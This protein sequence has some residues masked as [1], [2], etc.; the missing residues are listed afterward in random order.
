MHACPILSYSTV[1]SSFF[2][3]SDGSDPIG[4][5]TSF[6]L[7]YMPGPFAVLSREVKNC[8]LLQIECLFR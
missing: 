5:C 2:L 4:H 7:Y 3:C 8:A 6:K 1:Q